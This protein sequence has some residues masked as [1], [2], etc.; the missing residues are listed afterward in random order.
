VLTRGCSGTLV[1]VVFSD[2]IQELVQVTTGTSS[3]LDS[4]IE[5]PPQ[6]DWK[7]RVCGLGASAPMSIG[8]LTIV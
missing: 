1:T 8:G 6:P 4:A 3:A 7:A 5:S 2:V